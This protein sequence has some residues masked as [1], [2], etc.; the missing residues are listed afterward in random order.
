MKKFSIDKKFSADEK[1]S[2]EKKFLERKKFPS[3]E[4][5]LAM[6]R[7]RKIFLDLGKLILD[8]QSISSPLFPTI[9]FIVCGVSFGKF[10]RVEY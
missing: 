3:G 8:Q 10:G 1:F 7:P 4:N 6:F 5:R 2:I 9:P